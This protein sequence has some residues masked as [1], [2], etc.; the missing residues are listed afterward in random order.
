MGVD[1]G[2][3]KAASVVVDRDGRIMSSVTV[4]SRGDGRSDASIVGALWN[5]ADRAVREAGIPWNK[6]SAVGL[7][8]PGPVDPERGLW[9]GSTN[10][11]LSEPPYPLTEEI[12]RRSGR[13]A[14]AD[15]DVK[16]AGL[17]EYY[18]G[19]GRDLAHAAGGLLF[20]SVGTGLAA[21]LIVGGDVFRGRRDAGEM[22]HIPLH[23][24]GHPCACGQ[25]GCLE[26][27]ASGRALVR[28][29][30]AAMDANWRSEFR[31]MAEDDP[32]R[33]DGRMIMQAAQ[34]GDGVAEGLVDRLADGIALSVLVGFRAYDPAVVVLGGGVVVGGGE[35]LFAKVKD[36]LARKSPRYSKHRAV[37]VTKLREHAG[38]LGAAAV[39]LTAWSKTAH[40]AP[41]GV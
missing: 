2:G 39:A 14:F 35:Y 33:L 27:V 40:D 5:G 41:K 26:T 10:L 30:R 6:V 9:W 23:P 24:G 8:A 22:G 4:P 11:I 7:G 15:N 36:A 3:T 17:G 1:V 16:A 29:G 12:Q 21:S 32:S 13:P 18:F 31:A 38:A 37:E 19:Q 25:E 20:I 28:W 34:G